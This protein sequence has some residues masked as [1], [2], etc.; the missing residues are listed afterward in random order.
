M[1]IWIG[2]VVGIVAV[3]GLLAASASAGGPECDKAKA[4]SAKKASAVA[5]KPECRKDT[6]KVSAK[7]CGAAKTKAGAALTSGNDSDGKAAQCAKAVRAAKG[8]CDKTARTAKAECS[9]RAVAGKG[10]CGNKAADVALA[11]GKACCKGATC[12]DKSGACGAGKLTDLATIRYR[13]GDFQ[14][15]N[16]E[17]AKALADERG[18]GIEYVVAGEVFAS[19][20]DAKRFAAER[21]EAH[22]DRLLTVRYVVGEQ[23]TDCCET[24]KKLA[25]QGDESV[26]YLA[27]GRVFDS[28]E[29]ADRAV[30]A[31]RERLGQIALVVKVGDEAIECPHAA[32]LVAEKTGQ[33]VTYS[34]AGKTTRCDVTARYY[35]AL[36]RAQALEEMLRPAEAGTETASR[37]QAS[38]AKTSL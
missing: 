27:V 29:E 1:R 34:V 20:A 18:L 12:T 23:V 2:S 14:T 24:A 3:L 15:S 8:Q 11:A 19:L 32:R 4:C 6:A 28:R 13:V 17:A 25:S 10:R 16:L 9:K 38:A 30:A 7:G 33:P 36:A 26:R 37:A 35:Q 5:A 21:V 31:A 22:I